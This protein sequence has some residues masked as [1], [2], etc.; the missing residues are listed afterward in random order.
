MLNLECPLISI[1]M[2]AYNAED[3]IAKTIRSVQAQTVRDWQLLVI[4][5]GSKD[6]TAEIVKQFS[7]E[8]PRILLCINEQNVGVAKSR[9]RGL[10]LCRGKYI[11]F[12]D[13]DDMWHPE[14]LKIQQQTLENTGAALC[15]TAYAIVDAEGNRVCRDFQVPEE[16]SFQELLGKNVIGCSTVMMTGELGAAYSFKEDFFH[17]DYVLWLQ[18]LQDGHKAVGV[19]QIMV[20]YYFHRDSKAGNKQ[21]AALQRWKIYR[22]YLGFSPVKS[23][24]YFTQYALSALRKYRRL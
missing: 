2:C 1:V 18:I 13:S 19:K 17:E 10:S 24:W 22:G 12:L 5:D 9:N 15:Y 16:T 8:D 6:K 7:Q 11:A 3:V 14:K 23:L 21:N 20:D 4:D